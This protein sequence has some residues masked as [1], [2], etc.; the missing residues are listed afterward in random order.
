LGRL[1]SK[2]GG[3]LVLLLGYGCRQP[4]GGDKTFGYLFEGT[5]QVADYDVSDYIITQGGAALCFGDS[6]GGA[7]AN[8]DSFGIKRRL[9]AVNSKTD[10]N[11][12]SWLA[13]T[14][15]SIFQ[16]WVKEWPSKKDHLKVCGVDSDAQNCRQ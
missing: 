11:S 2:F 13:L 14:A 1:H 8:I 5:A 9:V 12:F 3:K 10:V 7:Y 15:H 4:G 16:T 6:G